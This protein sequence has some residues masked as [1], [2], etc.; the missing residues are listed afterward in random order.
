MSVV[1]CAICGKMLSP[2]SIG[3][4]LSKGHALDTFELR[5]YMVKFINTT[6]F[7][8]KSGESLIPK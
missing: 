5:E 4:H 3:T 6:E 7:F 1:K 8:C 2:K